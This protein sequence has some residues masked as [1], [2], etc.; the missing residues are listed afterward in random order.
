VGCLLVA[1]AIVVTLNINRQG[2]EFKPGGIL[3]FGVP[4]VLWLLFGGLL[5]GLRR[6]FVIPFWL[7]LLANLLAG[8][9]LA[10]QARSLGG[11]QD[12]QIF[13]AAGLGFILGSILFQLF[14]SLLMR[15]LRR[16]GA[17]ATR[18]IS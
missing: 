14:H 4:G 13:A 10:T 12:A 6:Y 16:Q 9:L 18:G 11:P 3:L 8:V 15:D 17:A 5:L 1:A 2:R 7:F